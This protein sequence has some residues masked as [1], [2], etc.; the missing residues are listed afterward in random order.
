MVGALGAVSKIL[1]TCLDKLGLTI[2]YRFVAENS[3]VGN[4][5]E[6]GVGKLKEES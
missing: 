4:S 5:K 3:F 1:D 2:K 6:E